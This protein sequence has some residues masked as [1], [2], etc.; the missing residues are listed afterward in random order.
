MLKR[1]LVNMDMKMLEMC[2]STD[3]KTCFETS[4]NQTLTGRCGCSLH[5]L[6]TSDSIARAPSAACT[7]RA[8]DPSSWHSPDEESMWKGPEAEAVAVAVADDRTDVERVAMAVRIA[9]V[10]TST[11]IAASRANCMPWRW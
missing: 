4:K 11:P 2:T 5:R 7:T 6:N 3:P 10:G 1:P 8:K 9:G